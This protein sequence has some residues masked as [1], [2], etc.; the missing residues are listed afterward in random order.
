M[1]IVDVCAFYTPHGGGVRTYV[2]RKLRTLPALGHEVVVIAPGRHDSVVRRGPGALFVTIA[3]PALPFDRRYHYFADRT[4]IHDALDA[5]RPDFIEASSPWS[6]ATKVAEWQGHAPRSLVMHADPLS[7]YAYRWL[8]PLASQARIDRLFDRF[9][10]HLRELD[11]AFDIV[12]SP[13]A[14]LTRRLQ[15]GGLKKVRSVPLG[16]EPGIFH[17]RRARSELR[18][19]LLDRL[20]LPDDGLILI[21]IGRFSA[22]KRWPM[23]VRAAA[24]AARRRPVGLLL[25]GAGKQEEKIAKEAGFSSHIEISPPVRS[26]AELASLLASS[27]AFVHGCESETFCLVASEARASGLPIIVP[28]RGGAFDQ[29]GAGAG[30]AYRAGNATA[31]RDAIVRLYD[32]PD[33]FTGR[34]RAAAGVRTMDEHFVDLMERYESITWGNTPALPLHPAELHELHFLD[35]ATDRRRDA[36]LAR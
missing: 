31:L 1:R 9:W 20:M 18:Q 25:I 14:S 4:G 29:L 32:T 3:S 23:V 26:R 34:V 11:K 5:W 15:A 2:D 19:E 21:G 30:L 22:E 12:V 28:D 27:D 16:V 24:S 8:G 6:S 13:G 36:L 7:S 35:E 17:P 33:A 10:K